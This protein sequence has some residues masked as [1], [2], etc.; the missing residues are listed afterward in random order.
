[1]QNTHG[2]KLSDT[3]QKYTCETPHD[4]VMPKRL[5]FDSKSPFYRAHKEREVKLV[6]DVMNV[7]IKPMFTT[8]SPIQPKPIVNMTELSTPLPAM[9]SFLTPSIYMAT[10]CV[11]DREYANSDME[12][13]DTD[14]D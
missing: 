13:A 5:T 4:K 2:C 10:P 8:E 12:L 3:L 9:S 11:T 7:H 1:M 14:S 6:K